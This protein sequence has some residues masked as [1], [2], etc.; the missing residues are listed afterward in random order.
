MQSR[1]IY[2]YLIL[3]HLKYLVADSKDPWSIGSYIHLRTQGSRVRILVWEGVFLKLFYQNET[4]GE[5]IPHN[6]MK[7]HD[8][9]SSQIPR[10]I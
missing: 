10:G 8:F 1:S 3:D 6:S 7:K 9:F 4:I 5:E 2:L